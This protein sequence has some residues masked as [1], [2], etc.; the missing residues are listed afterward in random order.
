MVVFG[1]KVWGEAYKNIF[2]EEVFVDR[3][4]KLEEKVKEFDKKLWVYMHW[5]T[6]GTFHRYFRKIISII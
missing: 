6:L 1:F 2:P 3:E 5:A 4:C